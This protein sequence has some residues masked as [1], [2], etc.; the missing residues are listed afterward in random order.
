M[1]KSAGLAFLLPHIYGKCFIPSSDIVCD[2][3]EVYTSDNY[4]VSLTFTTRG[5]TAA[6]FSCKTDG[7]R[8]KS[9]ALNLA[10]EGDNGHCKTFQYTFYNKKLK[11]TRKGVVGDESGHTFKVESDEWSIDKIKVM[12]LTDNYQGE[13]LNEGIFFQMTYMGLGVPAPYLESINGIKE[14]QGTFTFLSSDGTKII[15][16]IFRTISLRESD[17]GWIIGRD[18]MELMGITF[19]KANEGHYIRFSNTVIVTL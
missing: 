19:G 5:G 4:L 14:E 17:K 11:L 16:I 3:P 1:M 15:E 8:L 7:H 9:D 12:W 6:L 10:P 18:C 13:W 2:V